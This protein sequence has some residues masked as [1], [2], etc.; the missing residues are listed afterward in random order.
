MQNFKKFNKYWIV[1]DGT[2][3]YKGEVLRAKHDEGQ[4]V[5][6][7]AKQ[8]S[9]NFAYFY[10]IILSL[11]EKNNNGSR[12]QERLNE[13]ENI[14]IKFLNLCVQNVNRATKKCKACLV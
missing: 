5:Q 14:L 6:M 3:L 1:Y 11:E 2:D 10:H 13:S 7:K 8:K 4:V 12:L 9:E